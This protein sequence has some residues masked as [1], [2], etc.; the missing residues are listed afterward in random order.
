MALPDILE[1]KLRLPLISAPMFLASG[2][3]LIIECCKA[4]VIGAFPALNQRTTEGFDQWLT[5][6]SVKLKDHQNETG[7]APAPYAV[8][9]IVHKTNPRLEEDLNICI[10]HKVPM[11][12]TSLGAVETVVD[13][14]HSY[15]GIVFHDVINVRHARKAASVGVDGL[16]AVC[17]GAGGHAG[18]TNP[19]VLVNEIRQFFD[20]TLVVAGGITT[21]Q[22]IATALLMG[23]DLVYMG[24]RFLATVESLVTDEYKSMITESNAADIIYTPSISGVH[25]NFIRQSIEAVGLDVNDLAMP[26]SIDFGAEFKE[27]DVKKKAAWRDIWSAGQGVGSIDSICKVSELIMQ[28]EKE[29]RDALQRRISILQKYSG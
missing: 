27:K 16:I 1:N 14:V 5:D 12:I 6:I 29:Y 24:T 23:A 2:P 8:N 15:G 25:A 22:D 17:A 21:G 7:K 4:G 11:I 20:K 13:A 9:L 10:K 19:F 18:T 26:E 3:D 28:L